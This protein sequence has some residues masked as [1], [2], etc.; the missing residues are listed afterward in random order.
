MKKNKWILIA[1]GIIV[2]V[3]AIIYFK[4]SST[5]KW[6]WK[7][8]LT[9]SESPGTSGIFK[10]E[11]GSTITKQYLNSELYQKCLNE[12]AILFFKN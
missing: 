1:I 9:K 4:D 11:D 7:N 8:S 5:K 12:N 6:C 10:Q 3:L 2:V